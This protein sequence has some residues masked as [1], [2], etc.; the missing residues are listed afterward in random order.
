MRDMFTGRYY[1]CQGEQM[2]AIIPAIHRIQNQTT[3]SI[4]L[5]TEQQAWNVSFPHEAL[6][7][8][9]S[10]LI[11][12][13]NRFDRTGLSL[14]LHTPQLTAN[15]Q[16]HFGRFTP[17]RYDI[18]GPFA[19]I[20][21]MECRHSVSSMRHTVNGSLQINGVRFG[22]ANGAGY[23]EGDRGYSFPSEYLWTQCLFPGGSL[24][25]SVA[26][27]PLGHHTFT[28]VIGIIL[29]QGKEYRLA[30]YLGAAAT[31]IHNG[32]VIVRQG[33]DTLSVQLPNRPSKALLAPDGGNMTRIIRESVRCPASYR[34]IQNGKLL[35]AFTSDRAS[36]EY[37]Y[38]R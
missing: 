28:G 23:L 21:R 32:K 36:A 27:I 34:F 7:T 31:C 6:Q 38:N 19:L 14:S 5:I 35:F 18:M 17:I 11:I 1:K 9:G 26:E 37:E 30:S 24:M 20:P 16:L 33:K 2:L 12:G 29:F 4:Q 8:D 13:E 22:F 3:C 10:R 15:G 25:L